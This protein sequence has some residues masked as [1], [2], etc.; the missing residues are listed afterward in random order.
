MSRQ[1]ATLTANS[2]QE[3]ESR[4]ILGRISRHQEAVATF[5]TGAT[6]TG[7]SRYVATGRPSVISRRG[8]PHLPARLALGEEM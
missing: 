3:A 4:R 7:C 5:S 6:Y 8:Q 1:Q 2:P